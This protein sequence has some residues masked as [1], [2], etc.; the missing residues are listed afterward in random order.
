MILWVSQIDAESDNLSYKTDA[1]RNAALLSSATS[2]TNIGLVEP[3][4]EA[5]KAALAT[6][7]L[8]DEQTQNLMP[9]QTSIAIKKQELDSKKI[10]AAENFF[11]DAFGGAKGKA[12]FDYQGAKLSRKNFKLKALRVLD[13]Q[14][15]NY[16]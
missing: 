11:I 6:S 16:Y 14:K 7:V 9:G 5:T 4:A 12:E 3:R 13:A 10:D 15:G 1:E 2:K 8:K